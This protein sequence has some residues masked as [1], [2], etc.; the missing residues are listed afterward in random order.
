MER[1]WVPLWWWPFAAVIVVIFVAEVNPG[2]PKSWQVWSAI[3]IT[4]V[5]ASWLVTVSISRVGVDA[6]GLRAGAAH[7]PFEAMG[8][9][10]I[11]EPTTRRALHGPAG[12]DKAYLCTR[13]WVRGCVY[14]EVVDDG[15]PTPYWLVSTRDPQRLAAALRRADDDGPLTF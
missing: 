10:R 1:L 7:L 8:A 2:L 3:L 13:D 14:V 9:V 4:L 11:V 12:D 6:A 15:D 5:V